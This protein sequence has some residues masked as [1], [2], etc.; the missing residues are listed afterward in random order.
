M[1]SV[2]VWLWFVVE[3]STLV[4]GDSFTIAGHVEAQ[5]YHFPSE[6]TPLERFAAVDRVDADTCEPIY[7]SNAYIGPDYLGR[8]KSSSLLTLIVLK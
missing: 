2:T 3:G 4:G 6:V 8:G 5:L 7:D 1:F